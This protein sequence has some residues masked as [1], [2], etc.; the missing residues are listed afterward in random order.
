MRKRSWLVVVIAMAMCSSSVLAQRRTTGGLAGRVEDQSGAV[1]QSATVDI[2]SDAL[3]GGTRS[4][5]TD[6]QG[7]FRLPEL[8]PGR[9]SISVNA[10]GHQPIRI[11][12]VPVSVGLTA[13]VPIKMPAGTVE[14]TIVVR[15]DRVAVDPRTS[16][17]P[18]ILAPSYMDN[19]PMDRDPTHILDQAPAINMESAYGGG[20]ESGNAYE[21]DGVDISDPQDGA[22]WALFNQSLV[23]EV[24]LVG[25]GAPAEYGQF[26]GVIFNSVTKSGG[27]DS[28][29]SAEFYYAGQALAGNSTLEDLRASIDSS[30][31]SSVQVGGPIQKDK[32][33][34]FA[35]GQYVHV[36][37]NEGGPTQREID[38]RVFLKLTSQVGQ[39]GILQ[40]WMQWD[41]T[42]ITGRNGDDFTPREATTGEDNPELVGNLSWN[43]TLS[44]NSLLNVAWGGYSGHHHFDPVNGFNLPGHFDAQTGFASVNAQ[45][46]GVVDRRRGQ[47]NASL[48]HYIGDHELK[49]GTEIER[50]TIRDFYGYP[51]GAFF[52]D[53]EGPTVDPSTGKPDFYTLGSFGGG[54]DAHG[55][56][57]RTSMFVQDTWRITPRFTLNPGVRLDMNRGKVTGQ[58]VFRTNPIAPRLG[59]AWDLR[60]DARSVLRAH[61]GRYYEALYGAFY[62]YMDPGAFFPLITKRTFNTSGYTQTLTTTPGQ[63]YA[64]DPHIK[65][66]HLDQAIIGFD[67]QVGHD[68]VVSGTLV[69]R[70]NGDLIETVSRDGVF[71]PV[72][73][74]VPDTGQKVTLYDYLNPNTDVLI[75]TNP[76]SLKRSYSAAIL[77]ANR[78]LTGKWQMAAS[79]VFSRAK[80]NID[81]FGF[82]EFGLGAN[83]PFFDGHFLDT[84][85]SLVNAQGRLTHDQ[86]HQLKLQGA[87]LFPS[88]H[89]S[90]SADLTMHSGDTWTPRTTCLL[91]DDGNGVLGDGIVGCHDFPQ[92]PVLYLAESRGSRR[93]PT[94]R[95]LNLRTE[96]KHPFRVGELRVDFDFF[97]LNNQNRPTS[98]ETL[99]GPDLGQPATANYARWLRLGFGFT[100]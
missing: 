49:A 80:G 66:P 93:L 22:P 31:E 3:I 82:D 10:T 20:E 84:P 85:N 27:N 45:Q 52:M 48:S 55:Q 73:G 97:N 21:V 89:L 23:H 98:V 81:N 12:G 16:S 17:M 57:Q 34:Y 95:E 79:Y 19:I 61:Y 36:N 56:N 24:E 60:G 47:L 77:S 83:T 25:L 70:K 7:R 58:T 11:E 78:R 35:S 42:K 38:P 1:V 54:Y 46:F 18:T 76:R 96:W 40:G 100:W 69:Y 26:T 74:T 71:V 8:P 68:I 88:R 2:R 75:Y 37:S 91:T 33:W 6:A 72:T 94:K 39:N 43:M 90:V 32:L 29:G 15:G 50:A 62:Y 99:V 64:I 65:Q 44:P 14:E 87:R 13:E 51:G 30:V 63:Q 28:D 9:Y 92:G 53:N 67:Q 86:T 4:T 5:L 59:F 41:H